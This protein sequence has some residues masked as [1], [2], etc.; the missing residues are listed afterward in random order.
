MGL[1]PESGFWDWIHESRSL[2][3]S[4]SETRSLLRNCLDLGFFIVGE[5]LRLSV[6]W[7][8]SLRAFVCCGVWGLRESNERREKGLVFFWVFTF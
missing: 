2:I 1:E 3:V 6:S 4:L 7:C 8:E 5:F